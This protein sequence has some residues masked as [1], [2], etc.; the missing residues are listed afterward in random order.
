MN[1]SGEMA[2][3]LHDLISKLAFG[4]FEASGHHHG[5]DWQDWF[6][7]ERMVG[8]QTARV[9]DTAPM[10][11]DYVAKLI[12]RATPLLF[13]IYAQLPGEDEGVVEV[14]FG[15]SGIFV[16]PSYTLTALH[17]IE[18]FNNRMDRRRTIRPERPIEIQTQYSTTLVQIVDW[19][20]ENPRPT[21]SWR[22]GLTCTG[23]WTDVAITKVS[24]HM[25]ETE[26]AQSLMQTRFFEWSL[27]PPP[28]GSE[29][30]MLGY[31]LSKVEWDGARVINT[32]IKLEPVVA[33]VIDVY[34][35]RKKGKDRWPCFVVDKPVDGGFSGGPVFF[36]DKLCGITSSAVELEGGTNVVSMWP[37]TLL[38][39]DFG[40]SGKIDCSGLLDSGAIQAADWATVKPRRWTGIDFHE[41]K[42]AALQPLV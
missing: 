22:G 10:S 42:Y 21:A 28:V 19:Y 37:V 6:E 11:P 33:R 40:A 4:L 30:A 39:H 27:L 34:P 1:R 8:A 12:K 7:A 15:G 9:K 2:H 38:A 25:G 41:R 36:D 20:A 35:V 23:P 32:A 26:L 13:G 16:C 31:P 14:R 24:A 17:I 3:S 29:V 5:F 18:D